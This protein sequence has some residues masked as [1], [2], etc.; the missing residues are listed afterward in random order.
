MQMSNINADAWRQQCASRALTDVCCSSNASAA[1]RVDARAVHLERRPHA[2]TPCSRSL[3]PLC[4]M[5]TLR[6]SVAGGP[7]TLPL[8]SLHTVVL[9]A[10]EHESAL[11]QGQQPHTRM[12]LEL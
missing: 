11:L 7:R 10:R 3:R 6:C 9:T 4:V 8:W 1:A 12:Q 5:I 2:A